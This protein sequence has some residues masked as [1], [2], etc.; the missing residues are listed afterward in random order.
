MSPGFAYGAGT[1]SLFIRERL[2]ESRALRKAKKGIPV[3]SIPGG[4]ARKTVPG[5][6]KSLDF[7]QT[8]TQNPN[9]LRRRG[10]SAF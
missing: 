3:K 2:C 8:V 7:L 5:T 10:E 6:R 1:D 9:H 4:K